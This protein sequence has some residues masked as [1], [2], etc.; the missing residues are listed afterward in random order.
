MNFS[1][2]AC[3]I[4][5]CIINYFLNFKMIW[6]FLNQKQEWLLLLAFSNKI[7]THKRIKKRRLILII[8]TIDID[9]M[10]QIVEGNPHL[11]ATKWHF[12]N[13][14]ETVKNNEKWDVK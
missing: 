11:Q 1:S 9:N 2:Y 7:Q 14:C 6:I 4:W 10:M 5:F 3:E 12:K 13:N 8:M